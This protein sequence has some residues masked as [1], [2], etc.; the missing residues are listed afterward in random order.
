VCVESIAAECTKTDPS[1]MLSICVGFLYNVER[2][3]CGFRPRYKTGLKIGRKT[4]N[5]DSLEVRLID[6]VSRENGGLLLTASKSPL[7][8]SLDLLRG[9]CCYGAE[10]LGNNIYVRQELC[11]YC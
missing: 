10:T 8:F 5:V 1:K 2:Y 7:V 3:P 4:L 6:D 9:I 11:T